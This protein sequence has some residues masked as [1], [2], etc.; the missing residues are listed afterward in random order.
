[1]KSFENAD[2][3]FYNDVSPSQFEVQNKKF[4]YVDESLD[5]PVK[6]KII[7]DHLN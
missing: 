5:M 6:P 7:A 3:D 4:D 2:M 1:M